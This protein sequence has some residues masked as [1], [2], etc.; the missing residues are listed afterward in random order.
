MTI[1]MKPNNGPWLDKSSV[2]QSDVVTMVLYISR[3]VYVHH[4]NLYFF[5]YFVWIIIG[6]C[7]FLVDLVVTV[8]WIFAYVILVYLTI[9]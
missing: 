6:T 1:T 3:Y 4:L 9:C 8:G 7:L 5:Y 2:Y